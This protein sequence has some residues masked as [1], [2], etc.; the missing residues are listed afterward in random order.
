[1]GGRGPWSAGRDVTDVLTVWSLPKVLLRV[2]SIQKY[3]IRDTTESHGSS[4][5]TNRKFLTTGNIHPHYWELR[6]SR[7]GGGKQ[8]LHRLTS[9]G[10]A[11][12]TERLSVGN[13]S[14]NGPPN[15]T[16]CG[17][18]CGVRWQ[19]QR[20]TALDSDLT[21]PKAPSTLRSAGALQELNKLNLAIR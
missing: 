15:T 12:A 19:A 9:T 6:V 18:L 1:M 20:A 14:P 2:P 17:Q 13:H 7:R 10:A 8:C 11:I 4:T 21:Q 3:D 5:I 16:R